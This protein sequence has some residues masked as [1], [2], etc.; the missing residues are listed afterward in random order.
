MRSLFRSPKKF[1]GSLQYPDLALFL[2]LET[3]V[4]WETPTVEMSTSSLRG[5]T[6]P[7]DNP[8][9]L[10][11]FIPQHL[12]FLFIPELVD[13]VEFKIDIRN[14]NVNLSCVIV[15]SLPATLAY[16]FII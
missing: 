10:K 6:L 1:H 5:I 13:F 3:A 12:G 2:G 11:P 15:L 8:H 14:A 7:Q 9:I 4:S 16:L